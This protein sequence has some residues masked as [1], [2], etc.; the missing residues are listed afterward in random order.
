MRSPNGDNMGAVYVR[1][2]LSNAVDVERVRR[3]LGTIDQVRSC[4]VDALV[5]TGATRSAVPLEIVESLGLTIMAKAVG[6][7]ADGSSSGVGICSPIGF[8]IMGRETFE[9][10]YVMGD[11]ILI[12]QTTLE[13]TDLLVDCK[14]Q[15]VIGKHPEGP[16]F[17]L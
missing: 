2:R 13:A 9:E 5:D 3:G 14:N 7:L 8:E 10:A 4:E 15:R 6:R 12:G 1:V 17:R 11:E 16:V